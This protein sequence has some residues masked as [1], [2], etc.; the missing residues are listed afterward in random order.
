VLQRNGL[1]LLL[2]LLSSGI[3]R[4]VLCLIDANILVKHTA[5]VIRIEE[6]VL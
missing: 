2:G 4:H 6:V 5:S 3:G 1:F